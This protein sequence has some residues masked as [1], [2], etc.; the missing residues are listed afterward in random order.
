MQVQWLEVE[1]D[2]NRGLVFWDAGSNVNLVRQE[3]A[4]L[5]GWV[6]PH[7]VQQQQTTGQGAGEWRITAYW[8]Q[9]VDRRG[10]SHSLLVFEI[11]SIMA[12]MTPVEVELVLKLFEGEIPDLSYVRRLVGAVDLLLGV[13]QA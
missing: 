4:R 2:V 8:A 6:G 10:L 13:Q 1:G 5:A 3:F 12:S 7:V 9:L 11:G